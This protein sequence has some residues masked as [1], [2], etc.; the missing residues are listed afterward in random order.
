[1]RGLRPQER[2][3]WTSLGSEHMRV[4]QGGASGHGRTIS[5]KQG[6]DERMRNLHN[7]PLDACVCGRWG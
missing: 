4:Q 6:V 5:V 3:A 2:A 7:S 1:M